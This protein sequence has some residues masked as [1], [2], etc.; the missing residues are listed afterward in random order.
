MIAMRKFCHSKYEIKPITISFIYHHQIRL[1]NYEKLSNK[2]ITRLESDIELDDCK[3]YKSRLLNRNPRN[4]EQLSFEKKPEGFWFE[5]TAP[6]HWNKLVFEQKGR[7][8]DAYLQHWS[9]KKLV[10][11]STGEEQLQKYF[12]SP[13]TSQAAVILGE[14]ISRRCLQS[15]HLYAGVDDEE[16][17]SSKSKGFYEAVKKN[18]MTLKE[19]PEITPRSISDV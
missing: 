19:P 2:R 1:I 17:E 18:G 13:T 8:L 15:G 6:M 16:V 7:F 11:A 5:K 14:V 10:E 4:L 9:G 12:N 3:L